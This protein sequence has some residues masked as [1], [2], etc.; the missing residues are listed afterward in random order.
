MLLAWGTNEDVKL[1]SRES[2]KT[3]EPITAS[4][5]PEDIRHGQ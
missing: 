3:N 4:A 5:C 1:F 2:N